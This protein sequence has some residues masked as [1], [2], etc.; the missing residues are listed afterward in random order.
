M[1]AIDRKRV[2][3]TAATVGIIKS[4]FAGSVLK[5]P[6]LRH[7][8]SYADLGGSDPTPRLFRCR[9]KRKRAFHVPANEAGLVP[10]ALSAGESQCP[11]PRRIC[12]I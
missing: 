5:R 11:T 8:H 9:L 6:K 7:R 10:A 12:R 1:T 3:L 4:G 2:I